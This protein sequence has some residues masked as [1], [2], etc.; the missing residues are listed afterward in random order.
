MSGFIYCQEVVLDFSR[1][2][3]YP[4]NNRFFQGEE[5]GDSVAKSNS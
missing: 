5:N 1:S 4:R 2:F 3:W